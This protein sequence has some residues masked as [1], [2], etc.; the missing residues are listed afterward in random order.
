M[1]IPTNFDARIREALVAAVIA[2]GLLLIAAT[3][4]LEQLI[5]TA[6]S[7]LHSFEAS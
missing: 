7:R 2:F 6:Q 1:K 3:D 4:P 5:W